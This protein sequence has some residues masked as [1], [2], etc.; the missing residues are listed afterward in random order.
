MSYFWRPI[1]ER[2]NTLLNTYHIKSG[3]S[4]IKSA[5][6]QGRTRCCNKA[7]MEFLEERLYCCHHFIVTQ[8]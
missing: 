6:K 1:P 5:A 3:E 7:V 4:S 8:L 2:D